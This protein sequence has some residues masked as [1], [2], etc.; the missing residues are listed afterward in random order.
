MVACTSSVLIQGVALFGSLL[1]LLATREADATH[2][3]PLPMTV[4]SEGWTVSFTPLMPY[5]CMPGTPIPADA[6]RNFLPVPQATN[7]LQSLVG[8]LAGLPPSEPDGY[9][10]GYADLGFPLPDP[11]DAPVVSY[12]CAP[13]GPHEDDCDN[14][15]APSDAI[16]MPSTRYC[17]ATAQR[18]RTVIGHELFHHA[19][20]EYI[21]FSDWLDWGRT[22]VEGSARMMEDQVFSDLDALANSQFIRRANAYLQN[23]QQGFWWASYNAALGW[24]YAAEQF[25][26]IATEP[27]RGSDFV[28][29]FWENARETDITPG[30]DTPREFERTIQQSQPEKRLQGWF[31][32]FGIANLARQYDLSNLTP[33]QVAR[34]TYVDENDGNGTRF[35]NVVGFGI[36]VPGPSTG[37]IPLNFWSTF[38]LRA[39]NVDCNPGDIFGFRGR[40]AGPLL[41]AF[42]GGDELRWAVL[43]LSSG[44]AAT[45][46]VEELIRA[47]GDEFGAAFVLDGATDIS[48][49][50]A[51]LTAT[52][53]ARTVD[54]AFDCGPG[55]MTIRR[56]L[57]D[58]EAFVGPP[59]LERRPFGVVVRV[60]GPA[61]ISTP[62]VKGLRREDFRIYVGTNNIP[63]DQGDILSFTEV[64]E[65]YFLT[66]YPP[67][68]P[69]TNTYD[70]H[71]N[72][73]SI[74]ATEP[75]AVSYQEKVVHEMIALDRSGSMIFPGTPGGTLKI[76]AAKSA[77]SQLVDWARADGKIGAVAFDGDASLVRALDDATA[78]NKIALKNA[79]EAV[80]V[81]AFGSTSIGDAL[82]RS[83]DELVPSSTSLSEDWIL[84]LSD[85]QENAPLFWGNVKSAI[86]SAG[87]RVAAFG[88]GADADHGLLTQIADATDGVYIPVDA[89]P[90]SGAA[91]MLAGPAGPS[92]ED[93]LP[94]ALADAFLVAGETAE[95]LVRLWEH[96]GSLSQGGTASHQIDIQ[97]GGIDEATFAFHWND[98]SAVVAVQITRPDLSVVTHGVAGAEILSGAAHLVFHVGNLQQGVW[99]I[100][101]TATTGDPT[102]LGVLSGLDRQGPRLEVEVGGTQDPAHAAA[103]IRHVWGIPQIVVGTLIG[104]AIGQPVEDADVAAEV[105]HPDGTTLALKLL[106]DGEH[107]DGAAG[108]GVYANAY[109]RTTKALAWESPG[110]DGSYRV[111]VTATGTDSQSE[112]FVRIA[113]KSFVVGELGDPPPDTDGDGMPDRYEA[114]HHCLDPLVDDKDADSDL[115]TLRNGPEWD[116]GTD[117]CHPDT[118]RGGE[119]D[120]SEA[121]RAANPFD[122]A[123]DALPVPIDP[124]VIDWVLEHIP[125]PAGV[126]LEP[127]ENLIRYPRNAAYASMEILRA[128]SDQG[129]FTT[130]ATLSGPTLTGLY[131]D[132][133]L[134]NGTLYYYMVRPRDLNGNAGAPSRIFWGTPKADPL[135]PIGS[136]IINDGAPLAD[137][138]AATLSLVASHD[139]GDMLIGDDPGFTGAVWQPFADTLP[140]TLAPDTSTGVASVYVKLR[141]VNGN[142]SPSV[143]DDGVT[144]L[145]A[146]SLGR[147]GG[148]VS[149]TGLTDLA[150]ISIRIVSEPELP[151]VYTDAQG[152][153]LMQYLP[154]GSYALLVER[155]GYQAVAVP[156][157]VISAGGS[158][159]LG[160]IALPEPGSLG[161]AGAAFSVLLA[162]RR[163]RRRVAAF[164]L[165]VFFVGSPIRAHDLVVPNALVATFADF[166]SQHPLETN[167]ASSL[168]YQQVYDA[169]LLPFDGGI[170]ITSIAFRPDEIASPATKP[171]DLVIL[172]STTPAEPDA[173]S[174]TFD[175]NLGPEVVI[176]RD[177]I[178]QLT[179]RSRRP[180]QA[181]R[182]STS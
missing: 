74:S 146:G 61:A 17:A 134:V 175:D 47:A 95:G 114:L 46:R 54:F 1:V 113:K 45:E 5:A 40:D 141:D 8:P 86:Q 173:L 109:T 59:G 157:A 108:D 57:E 33:A 126:A 171:L 140:W 111:V 99:T 132:T 177:G 35:A 6:D 123:D 75:Q 130:I 102:Y 143:Y 38:Y 180:A 83:A 30:A 55:A 179:T 41:G 120:G 106:D 158:V 162:L 124:E 101:V 11:G 119:S 133:G 92:S 64:G 110:N 18:I 20:F 153:F 69:D 51:V 182:T 152:R 96:E 9:L 62:V 131:E 49:I 68:K 107:G 167:M 2:P 149:A 29:R 145:P 116:A 168:R 176:I 97:E 174:A 34:Y 60:T 170:T 24:K 76:L 43:A 165:G 115:D 135:P 58:Y 31:H 82:D 100:D 127:G 84:L 159:D 10:E 19:Q 90:A 89:D 142:E 15:S 78:G 7:M 48:Q 164:V 79:I 63:A 44:V 155:H 103:G 73:G 72:L 22:A 172:L 21:G 121:L 28:R 42:D 138:N 88:L 125:F 136:V 117:P 70:L 147:F 26:A 52:D 36:N 66:V 91:P 128:T 53:G 166:S 80:D 4:A 25:G 118:D 144:V 112:G 67:D 156:N 148:T 181:P 122:P 161:A 93:P 85:G 14:G 32:D 163:G 160:E 139:V 81:S 23:P 13:D 104:Q 150:G 129:P 71:V 3:D 65:S 151:P 16:L 50:A 98:A 37:A 87:I 178:I 77:A 39:R 105:E 137:T 169:A 94:N 27:E 12:D 154:P 56:P